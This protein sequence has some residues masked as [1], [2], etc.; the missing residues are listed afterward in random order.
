ME[1][2]QKSK[3]K[4]IFKTDMNIPLANAIRRSANEIPILAINEVDI[5]KND[6]VLYDEFLA[7]RIG[8]IP[9]KNQK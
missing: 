5:Y 8:L 6:S 1:K 4:I 3:D 9:L 2:I 7:H